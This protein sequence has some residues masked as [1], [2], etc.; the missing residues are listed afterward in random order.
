MLN[1]GNT[2]KTLPTKMHLFFVAALG[3][4]LTA[5]TKAVEDRVVLKTSLIKQLR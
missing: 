5:K 3:L 4:G 2:F 1:P